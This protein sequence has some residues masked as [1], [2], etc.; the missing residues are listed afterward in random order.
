MMLTEPLKF[1]KSCSAA[2]KNNRQGV[3]H[4]TTL[5]PERGTWR[6]DLVF[7]I[8]SIV[9]DINRLGNALFEPRCSASQL[10]IFGFAMLESQLG[11]STE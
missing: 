6:E 4:V 9:Q 8:T 3:L 10:V 7:G 11:V 5:L 2:G 1:H